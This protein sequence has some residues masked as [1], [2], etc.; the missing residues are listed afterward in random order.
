MFQLLTGNKT[1]SNSSVQKNIHGYYSCTIK[2]CLIYHSHLKY[3]FLQKVHI[4]KVI[5]SP[6]P[7]WD[8]NDLCL[9]FWK[10][11][12]PHPCWAPASQYIVSRLKCVIILISLSYFHLQ[13]DTRSH[14]NFSSS[15]FGSGVQ[16]S[17]N[18][19]NIIPITFESIVL[20]SRLPTCWISWEIRLR[21]P[22]L[23]KMS[24]WLVGRDGNVLGWLQVR[25]TNVSVP[26]SW[27]GIHFGHIWVLCVS[28]RFRNDIP[29]PFPPPCSLTIKYA[30]WQACPIVNNTVSKTLLIFKPVFL[31]P[32]IYNDTTISEA[33]TVL[34]ISGSHRSLLCSETWVS[35]PGVICY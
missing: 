27:V 35:V 8:Q 11:G 13:I 10:E 4:P 24:W 19:F 15:I 25:E 16:T 30:F 14:L 33:F 22:F 26:S 34:C 6:D 7:R 20:V 5:G 18:L 29:T 3:Q 28:W 12:K 9:F 32:C 1:N 2:Q 31:Q 17:N 21:I 23:C